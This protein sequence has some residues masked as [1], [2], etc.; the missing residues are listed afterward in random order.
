[1]NSVGEVD[2]APG[3]SVPLDWNEVRARYGH[4]A[5]VS[6]VAGGKVLEVTGADE[7][8]IY[9]RGGSLWTDALA[10]SDL[11]TAARMLD[12]GELP[13]APVAFVEAYHEKVSP[14]R[15]TAVAHI[16][17]DFGLLE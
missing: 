11:E 14:R 7:A 6:T 17:K 15:G 10:R 16:M 1:M 8:H 12:A 2:D 13:R 4:G 9:I 5:W 3:G